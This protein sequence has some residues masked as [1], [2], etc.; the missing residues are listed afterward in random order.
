M[1]SQTDEA[2]RRLLLS[3]AVGVVAMVLAYEAQAAISQTT[4]FAQLWHAARGLL[5][6]RNPY[7]IV[8]PHGS[9]NWPFPLL[10]PL[11][12]VIVASPLTILPLPWANA[13]F[14]A[15]GSATVAW[16]LP[17]ERQ[18]RSA[19]WWL[20]ASATFVYVVR[21]AQW[22]PLLVGAAL[23]PSL[24]WLLAC[25]PTIGAALFAAYP[26]R[27]AALGICIFG[28]VSL[29]WLPAWP[30]DWI[31]T[32][33]SASHMSAPVT[34]VTA[35]GPLLLLALLRWRRP[36][37]RL[38]ASLA[39]I[40]HTTMLYEA[41]PLFLVPQRWQE[42]VLLAGL[43][44]V[45]LALP[46]SR[47]YLERLHDTAWRMTLLLYLPCLAMV[48]SRSNV[49]DTTHPRNV[50]SGRS[51]ESRRPGRSLRTNTSRSGS[52]LRR[53]IRHVVRTPHNDDNGSGPRQQLPGGA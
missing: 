14:V 47:E 8:G 13:L 1:S 18:N 17:G 40:P 45:C 24:G 49:H 16:A 10:Y 34:F 15:I 37:A 26:T 2:I 35:G 38:I 36:E 12:A 41:L 3:V 25:K 48:L 11:T 32:L 6:G 46:E 4:D 28:I 22:G 53:F 27:R 7:D 19:Q 29:L 23:T 43:S 44:W 51:E 39:C 52:W 30:R 5:Q 20:F 21:T 31:A 9:F 42:G 50:D 33:P